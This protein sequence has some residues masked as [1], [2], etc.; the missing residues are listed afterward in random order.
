M[1]TIKLLKFLFSFSMINSLVASEPSTEPIVTAEKFISYKKENGHCGNF[2]APKIVLI[3]YQSSTLKY[4][5]E[6]HPELAENTDFSNLYLLDE[7]KVGILGGWGIGAP[8]LCAKMEQL[9]AYGCKKFIAIGT[10]GMLMNSHNIG[11]VVLCRSALAEDGVAHLYLPKEE[12]FAS[13]SDSLAK[14]WNDFTKSTDL[15]DISP[16]KAWSFSAIFKESPYDLL[17]VLALGCTVVEMEAATL[18]A[19]AE[20]KNVEALTL[21]V[22]SDSLTLDS[23]TPHIKEPAVRNNLHNLAKWALEFC[24]TQDH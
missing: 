9:I 5:L 18:Y 6:N 20:E 19:L 23:W 21:F 7:G 22:V 17:R 16:C 24:H 3:C 13:M 4:F 15:P 8:A 10:A 11:D 1:K 2:Q 12:S 14:S